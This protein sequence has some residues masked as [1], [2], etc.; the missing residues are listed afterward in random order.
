MKH[1]ELQAVRGH[2]E[3]AYVCFAYHQLWQKQ[4]RFLCEIVQLSKDATQ[5]A[6]LSGGI[7]KVSNPLAVSISSLATWHNVS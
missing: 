3:S 6:E 2:S 4:K 7:L 1:Q 5:L